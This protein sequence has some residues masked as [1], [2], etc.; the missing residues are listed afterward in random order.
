MKTREAFLFVALLAA[1]ACGA[2]PRPPAATSDPLQVPAP[3]GATQD[4]NHAVAARGHTRPVTSRELRA[5]QPLIDAAARVRGL[6]F[7]REVPVLV[8][9]PDAIMAYVDSQI[10][11]DDLDRSRTIYVALG[12]LPADLDI[13]KLL[14]RLMG[15][16]IVGYYDVEAHHLVVREDVMRA[17]GGSSAKQTVDLAEARVVLVHE[18][19]HALQDQHLGLS[20]H[21]DQKRDSD[22]E[23]AFRAL[24]EGDATLAMIA[25]ALES[26]ALPLAELTRNPARVRNLSDL[27]R[28][29]PLA[30]SELGTAPPIVRVPL[31]S[32]Y[33][34]GLTF[35]ANLHGDGGWGRLDRAHADPPVSTEQVLHPERFARREAPERPRLPGARDALG[36]GYRLLH[37]DT[38]GE[39]EMSVYFGLGSPE[40]QAQRAGEGWGGDRLYAFGAANGKTAVLWL[41]S[42]D[43]EA[44]AIEAEQAAEHARDAAKPTERTEQQIVR[45]GRAL[46]M[47]R[48]VP[49]DLQQAARARF[50]QWASTL[51]SNPRAGT[52]SIGSN[53]HVGQNQTD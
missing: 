28:G 16:Q 49:V 45:V 4:E 3:K 9:D 32:A 7:V 27:V 30:G 15:E 36:R 12:L 6:P 53:S 20:E 51:P 2:S 21:I 44:Q 38:L 10:E 39:L 26:E 19:V 18:L 23:N 42:W 8:Q 1:C 33:V 37:E 5:I 17:F 46:L 43:D 11:K 29:S 31:L 13:R 24:I 52:A 34:D 25:F 50:E 40:A 41:T 14:L 48:N 35:A 47:T 22:A